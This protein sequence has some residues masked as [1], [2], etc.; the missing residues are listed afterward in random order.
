MFSLH[1][2]K[3]S[4]VRIAG[5]QPIYPRGRMVDIS[6]WWTRWCGQGRTGRAHGRVPL[7]HFFS[8]IFIKWNQSVEFLFNFIDLTKIFAKLN[9]SRYL[10]WCEVPIFCKGSVAL[11]WWNAKCNVNPGLSY[12]KLYLLACV[13]LLANL[14]LPTFTFCISSK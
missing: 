8:I 5:D 3:L 13:R 14:H 7:S 11:L 12:F 2:M 4:E 1:L 10:I 6:V 9:L